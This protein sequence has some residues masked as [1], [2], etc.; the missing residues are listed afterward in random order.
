MKDRVLVTGAAGFIGNHLANRLQKNDFDVVAIDKIK[1]PNEQGFRW[2]IGDVTDRHFLEKSFENF[3]YIFHVAGLVTAVS[4]PDKLF[5]EVHI[6]ST[7]ILCRLSLERGVERFIYCGSDSVVGRIDNE[8]ADENT[9]C[10]PENIYSRTKYEGERI[11]LKYFEEKG[12]PVTVLR[13]TWTYGPGDKRTLKLFKLLKKNK[14]IMIGKGD[15]SIHPL[16]IENLLDAFILILN[17]DKSI[18][19]V[20]I[21][22]DDKPIILKDFIYLISQECNVSLQRF[23]IPKSLAYILATILEILFYPTGLTPPLHRRRLSFFTSERKYSIEKAREILGYE[24]KINMKDGIKQTI[25]WYDNKGYFC[26]N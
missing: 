13:P 11:A 14:F 22:A 20:F 19:E 25:M 4:V 12:L 21:I 2:K 9:S 1:Y 18:G 7:D 5:E 23:Y 15:V 17:N 24:P 6:K 26:D 16:Y 10:F 8:P 3:K